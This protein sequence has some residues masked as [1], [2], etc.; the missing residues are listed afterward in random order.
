[1][2][3]DGV[4]MSMGAAVASTLQDWMRGSSAV[5]DIT[6]LGV[7]SNGQPVCYDD[8]LFFL[9]VNNFRGRRERERL[10]SW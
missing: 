4:H 10:R 3:G 1:M 7:L 2:K 9:S 6:S 8:H 5:E